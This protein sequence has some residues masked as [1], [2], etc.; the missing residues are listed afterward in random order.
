MC[1]GLLVF[2]VQLHFQSFSSHFESVHFIN[3]IK[4]R[5]R[6]LKTYKPNSFAF[7]ILF[8]HDSCT[9]DISKL[10][11][12][13]MKL[14][15][16]HIVGQMEQEQITSG[17]PKFPL[18]VLHIIE[19]IGLLLYVPIIGIAG[20]EN[21]CSRR[22]SFELRLASGIIVVI[23]LALMVNFMI[24]VLNWVSKW[25]QIL[26]GV[27]LTHKWVVL[28]FLESHLNW[29][30]ATVQVCLAVQKLYCQ[31]GALFFL[32][33]H[34]CPKLCIFEPD[35]FNFAQNGKYLVKCLSCGLSG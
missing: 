7:S 4:S 3:R 6:I 15:V 24:N 20:V 19:R 1:F 26:W 17:W 8:S 11:K 13:R 32:E 23:V 9:Q 34:E 16:F 21:L 14:R 5:P 31:K 30:A 28:S 33:I 29:N 35:R 12:Q 18:W 22:W 2:L 10:L 27:F 25:I